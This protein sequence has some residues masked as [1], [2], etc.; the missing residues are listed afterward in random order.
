MLL[1]WQQIA[2][3]YENAE[4]EKL[5]L[6]DAVLKMEIEISRKKFQTLQHLLSM[7]AVNS[8]IQ[9]NTIYFKPDQKFPQT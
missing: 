9:L 2:K 6:Q 8:F 3:N 4:K 7:L 1:S 5:L